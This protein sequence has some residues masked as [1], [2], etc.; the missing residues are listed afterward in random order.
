MR[1]RLLSVAILMTIISSP[2]AEA[3]AQGRRTQSVDL[4]VL[5]GT[6]VTMDQA[7]QVISDGGI[8]VS[9]GRILAIGS[10][11]DI[12]RQYTSRQRVD[13]TGKVITPGLINGRVSS[14]SPYAPGGIPL[15]LCLFSSVLSCC[16][17]RRKKQ[18]V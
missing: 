8:A 1:K 12:E 6:I 15:C 10:R 2:L 7:R 5:G 14:I 18:P 13:A 16:R 3:E 17:E 11:A 9:Q 4:L